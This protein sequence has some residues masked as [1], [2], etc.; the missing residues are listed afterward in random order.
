MT[1][2]HSNRFLKVDPVLLEVECRLTG[3]PLKGMASLY[4]QVYDRKPG[5]YHLAPELTEI[6]PIAR[7]VLDRITKLRPRRRYACRRSNDNGR[8]TRRTLVALRL[9][10]KL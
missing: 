8:S 7:N 5:W 4:V 2:E 9:K 10:W 1:R 6:V 3:V